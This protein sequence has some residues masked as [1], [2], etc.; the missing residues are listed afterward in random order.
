MGERGRHGLWKLKRHKG[1]NKDRNTRATLPPTQGHF[2]SDESWAILHVKWESW[3]SAARRL[4]PA[5]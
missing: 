3:V 1:M 2:S 5:R 4:Q